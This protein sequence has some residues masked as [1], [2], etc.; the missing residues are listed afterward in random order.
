MLEDR[1]VVV[2]LMI[3][4][5]LGWLDSEPILLNFGPERPHTRKLDRLFLRTSLGYGALVTK[6]LILVNMAVQALDIF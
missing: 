2:V 6:S 4:A 5:S 1:V 3:A